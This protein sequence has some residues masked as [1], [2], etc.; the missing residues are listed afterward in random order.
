M[1]LRKIREGFKEEVI[2]AQVL[3]FEE[4]FSEQRGGPSSSIYWIDQDP[5]WPWTQS[6]VQALGSVVWFSVLAPPLTR[7]VTLNKRIKLS[8]PQCPHLGR[9]YHKNSVYLWYQSHI[10]RKQQGLLSWL[11]VTPH[12]Y[13]PTWIW[14]FWDGTPSSRLPPMC[15]GPRAGLQIEAHVPYAWIFTS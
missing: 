4:N 7:C 13:P 6:R 1:W 12:P 10:A 11:V 14:S 3:K 5:A 15:V 8:G 9:R 2:F